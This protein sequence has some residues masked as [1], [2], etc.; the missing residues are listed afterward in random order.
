MTPD[1]RTVPGP[2]PGRAKACQALTMAARARRRAL[3]ETLRPRVTGESYLYH[4]LTAHG[5][6]KTAK[7]Y[8]R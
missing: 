6:L 5:W 3:L 2:T 8:R 1:R 7:E 4:V